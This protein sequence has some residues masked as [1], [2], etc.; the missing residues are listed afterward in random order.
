[1]VIPT[2]IQHMHDHPWY[3]HKVT[4]TTQVS[5]VT[6]PPFVMCTPTDNVLALSPKH[7][8]CAWSPPPHRQ[9][10]GI[11]N[12][13]QINIS[14]W[15]DSISNNPH[16]TVS[17]PNILHVS[18]ITTPPFVMCAPTDNILMLSP[19][20]PVCAWSPPQHSVLTKHPACTCLPPPYSPPHNTA[21]SPNILHVHAYPHLTGLLGAFSGFSPL[22][23]SLYQATLAPWVKLR[24]LP[25]GDLLA[26]PPTLF[27]INL[28]N[29]PPTTQVSPIIPPIPI[30]PMFSLTATFNVTLILYVLV[31][32]LAILLFYFAPSSTFLS[33]VIPNCS[34]GCP[35]HCPWLYTTKQTARKVTGDKAPRVKLQSLQ[36]KKSK[37]ALSL[38]KPTFKRKMMANSEWRGHLWICDEKDCK[39]VVCHKCLIVPEKSLKDVTEDHVTFKC[40][41]CHWKETEKSAPQPYFGFYSQGKPVLPEPPVITDCGSPFH[42]THPPPPGE[43]RGRY[44][45]SQL[46][47]NLTTQESLAA[48]QSAAFNLATSLSSYQSVIL[49]LTTHSDEERGDL[50]AGFVDGVTVALSEDSFNG[51]KKAAQL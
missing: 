12:S 16:H 22:S 36:K 25:T 14:H 30:P 3:Q 51:L 43:F 41:T 20:H 23:D 17:S 11:R 13:H 5:P 28:Y 29:G 32:V 10:Q 50:F 38:K 37:T 27:I 6:T 9:L 15:G 18:P 40:V 46:P 47:F 26:S 31:N 24:P 48:Y 7:P 42:C 33:C 1:M 2:T 49:F 8:V 44:Q 19:K 45:F 39:R 35:H 21:S 34:F 4:P